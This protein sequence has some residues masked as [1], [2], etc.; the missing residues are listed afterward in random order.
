MPGVAQPRLNHQATV[1]ALLFIAHRLD[2][3]KRPPDLYNLGHLLYLADRMH[4]EEYGRLISGERYH[5]LE[6]GPTPT[7]TYDALK[8]LAGREPFNDP[9]H[10]FL[11][12]IGEAFAS[13][14]GPRF[15][16]LRAA[17]LRYL[18][19]SAVACLEATLERG[20]EW[21]FDALKVETHRDVAYVTTR[22]RRPNAAMPIEEIARTLRDGDALVDYLRSPFVG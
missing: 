8:V 21:G 5:A 19:P 12:A 1:E 3:V 13:V 15:K 17:D 20:A 11:Q 10:E 14:G 18:S 16:P 22:E 4:L 6:Y 2:A 9:P 7:H